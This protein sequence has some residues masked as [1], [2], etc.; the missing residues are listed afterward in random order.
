M[1]NVSS[2]RFLDKMN[3]AGTETML[4]NCP[5]PDPVGVVNVGYNE[6]AGVICQSM[7]YNIR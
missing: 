7:M 2:P 4:I 6:I 5:H 3:C 1:G